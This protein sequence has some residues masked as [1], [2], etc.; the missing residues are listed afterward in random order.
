LCKNIQKVHAIE[1]ALQGK[2]FQIKKER[3]VQVTR[4]AVFPTITLQ[5]CGFQSHAR[6]RRSAEYRQPLTI[7]PTDCRH[8]AKING[9]EHPFKMGVRKTSPVGCPRNSVD[10]EFRLF[11]L[12]PSVPYSVR[13]WLKFRRNSAE[14]RVI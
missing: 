7:E 1:R 10:T 14:F 2:I 13:N 4:C 3:M 9:K 12:L 6:V 5:Y 11:F 8:A